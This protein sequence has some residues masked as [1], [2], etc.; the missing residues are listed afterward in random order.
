MMV[1]VAVG[2]QVINTEDIFTTVK[3]ADPAFLDEPYLFRHGSLY[4]TFVSFTTYIS[5]V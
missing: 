2:L 4:N 3:P 1:G 5:L